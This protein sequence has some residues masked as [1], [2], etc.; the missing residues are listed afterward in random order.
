MLR[1]RKEQM[2]VFRAYMR[3]QFEQRLVKHLREKF[4]DRT[5]DFPDESLRVVVQNSVKKAESYGI[6]YENDLRRFIEYWM[7]YGNQ[8]DIQEETRWIGDTLRRHDLD[9]T[10]KMDLIDSRELQALREQT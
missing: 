6:E 8:M 2:D 5:K 3:G 1:I 10:A 9:G 7:I 4:P